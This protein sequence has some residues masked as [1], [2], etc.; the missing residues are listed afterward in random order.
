MSGPSIRFFFYDW[1]GV[2]QKKFEIIS[3]DR[4]GNHC[5]GIGLLRNDFFEKSWTGNIVFSLAINEKNLNLNKK[6]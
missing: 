1:C 5:F 2:R 6:T 4:V 3:E